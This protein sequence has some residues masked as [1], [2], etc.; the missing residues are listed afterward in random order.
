MTATKMMLLVLTMTIMMMSNVTYRKSCQVDHKMIFSNIVENSQ[1]FWSHGSF[2]GRKECHANGYCIK[3]RKMK[4]EASECIAAL[5]NLS[6]TSKHIEIY[7]IFFH[8]I[9]SKYGENGFNQNE[10]DQS[11]TF[12]STQTLHQS[13]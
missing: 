10:I 3:I 13:K 1:W 11:H 4:L 12:F 9:F 2:L 7:V 8:L 6:R 5:M